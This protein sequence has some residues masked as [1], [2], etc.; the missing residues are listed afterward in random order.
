MRKFAYLCTMMLLSLNMTAQI[1]PYDHNWDTLLLDHFTSN[2]WNTWQQWSISHPVGFYKAFIPEWP[3]G[4]SR[5]AAEHQVYQR[6]NCVFDNNG[7]MRLVSVYE[8]GV[9][10]LPLTCGNYD[11]PPGKTCDTSHHTLYYSSGKIESGDKYLYGY[12]EIR[13]SLPIHKGAFPAFWLYGQGTNYYNEID[14]FEYSWGCSGSNHYK[15]FTCG[16]LCNNTSVSMDHY[17]RSYPILPAESADLRYPHTFACEWLPERVTWYVDGVVVNEFTD[18]EHIPHHEMSFKINYAIDNFSFSSQ[19]SQPDWF[20]GDVMTIDYIKVLKAD[21]NTD[22]LICNIQDV[23]KYQKTFKKT[24][25]IQ[26][27]NEFVIPE[28]INLNMRAVDSIVIDKG[29]TFPIG[30]QITLQMEPCPE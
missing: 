16:I 23:I 26:P 3:S 8:G 1:D 14:I 24:I 4:V 17:A 30:T 9:N 19:T 20:D 18:Y 29:V 12:F 28:N 11:I 13:C 6:E 15:Q 27:A 2:T 7:G 10:N 25:T 22:L 5:G 21:C